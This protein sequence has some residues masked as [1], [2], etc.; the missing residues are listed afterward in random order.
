MKFRPIHCFI[1][2]ILLGAGVLVASPAPCEKVPTSPIE[3]KNKIFEILQSYRTARVQLIAN[4]SK[5][6]S[7]ALYQNKLKILTSKIQYLEIQYQKQTPIATNFERQLAAQKKAQKKIAKLQA[8]ALPKFPSPVKPATSPFLGPIRS[9]KQQFA[10]ETIP[11]SPQRPGAIAK[12]APVHRVSVPKGPSLTVR[13]HQAADESMK[14]VQKKS[15]TLAEAIHASWNRTT[16]RLSQ[17]WQFVLS[18]ASAGKQFFI[19][20]ANNAREVCWTR[21]VETNAAWDN[22]VMTSSKKLEE[23]KTEQARRKALVQPAPVVIERVKTT[24]EAER[25]ATAPAPVPIQP[26]PAQPIASEPATIEP[27]AAPQNTST[28][29]LTGKDWMEMDETYKTL[30]LV[31]IMGRLV[32]YD[33]IAWKSQSF[34]AQAID[35]AIAA[36]PALQNEDLNVIFFDQLEHFEPDTLPVLAKIR[37]D[38]NG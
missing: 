4:K 27:E 29:G 19:T 2:V 22:L 32:N 12:P 18:Q 17:P 9:F 21:L 7:K 10:I 24:F 20:F 6:R 11:V 36:N 8:R 37:K 35:K 13:V 15:A 14:I 26:V 3:L 28:H 16:S 25:V 34:Y 38:F 23:W 5:S 33:V 31:S 30:H 1:C